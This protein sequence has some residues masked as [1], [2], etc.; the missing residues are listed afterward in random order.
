MNEMFKGLQKGPVKVLQSGLPIWYKEI[1]AES[2][3]RLNFYT[4]KKHWR[5]NESFNSK[6]FNEM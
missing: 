6:E 1:Q 2:I 4:R 5:W 3:D